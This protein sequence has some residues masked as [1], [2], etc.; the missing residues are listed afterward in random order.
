LPAPQRRARA[1][2]LA[3]LPVDVLRQITEL[4]DRRIRPDVHQRW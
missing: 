4:Y 3:P 1:A 2:E